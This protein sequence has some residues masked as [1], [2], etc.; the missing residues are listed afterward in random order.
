MD[1][2]ISSSDSTSSY[3]EKL[4]TGCCFQKPLPASKKLH[5]SF[6]HL[7]V[8]LLL[9]ATKWFPF[10]QWNPMIVFAFA[11]LAASLSSAVFEREEMMK[12]GVTS[13][14]SMYSK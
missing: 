13:S 12:S 11:V 3:I 5:L 2:R 10:H 8:T 14:G 1:C 6:L 9:R 7:F 4:I